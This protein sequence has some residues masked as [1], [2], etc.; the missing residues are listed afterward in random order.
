[1][2]NVQHIKTYMYKCKY[3]YR[4]VQKK[5]DTMCLRLANSEAVPSIFVNTFQILLNL[6]IRKI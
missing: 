4:V 1:M 2:Y 6:S 5:L 3:I